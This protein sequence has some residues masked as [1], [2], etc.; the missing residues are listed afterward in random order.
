[1]KLGDFGFSIVVD[2]EQDEEACGSLDYAAPEILDGKSRPGPEGDIW[3][4]GTCISPP[5][6]PP[7]PFCLLMSL[8]VVLYFMVTGILPFRASSDYDKFQKIRKADF[9][10][11]PQSLSHELQDLLSLIFNTTTR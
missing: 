10:L 4:L 6:I 7:C 2:S 8:G 1:M 3:A 11:L 5:L 9:R